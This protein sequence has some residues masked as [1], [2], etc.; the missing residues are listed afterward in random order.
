MAAVP[1]LTAGPMAAA[2]GRSR[3]CGIDQRR[4]RARGLHRGRVPR[5]GRAAPPRRRSRRRARARTRAA[6]D[7]TRVSASAAGT[8]APPRVSAPAHR[9]PRGEVFASSDDAI[10]D[11]LDAWSGAMGP[12]TGSGGYGSRRTSRKKKGRSANKSPPPR[13]APAARAHLVR[14]FRRGG[15]RPGV[16]A[17]VGVASDPWRP[18]RRPRARATGTIKRSSAPRRVNWNARRPRGRGAR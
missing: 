14:Q 17:A 12:Q 6:P 3:A 11:A 18:R 10:D 16:R 15:R 13:G 5:G 2:R 9:G 7:T 1:R 8:P 4:P